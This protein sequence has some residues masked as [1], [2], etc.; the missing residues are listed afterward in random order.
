MQKSHRF[1]TKIRFPMGFNGFILFLL[2]LWILSFL[3]GSCSSLNF[4]G[5]YRLEVPQG[6]LVDAE[7]VAQVQVGMEPRQ[8]RYLLGTPLIVDTFNPQRWDYRYSILKNDSETVDHHLIILFEQGR[9]ALIEDRLLHD[10]AL[11]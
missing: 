2:P 8:V 4:P 6:N 7:K 11:R 5:V 10:K 1:N 3:L 9:V